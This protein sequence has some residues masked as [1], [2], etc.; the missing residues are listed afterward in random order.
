M[1]ANKIKVLVAT[2]ALG[3]GFDKPDLGFVSGTG[4]AGSMI[5]YCQQVA[6][7]SRYRFCCW[8]LLC[9]SEDRAIHKFLR[10]STSCGGANS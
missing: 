7:R 9:G 3:M 4:I 8:H 6:V 1:L 2:T 10:E 5:G